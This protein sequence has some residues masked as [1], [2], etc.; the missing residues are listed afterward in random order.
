[1]IRLAVEFA[2]HQRSVGDVEMQNF[3]RGRVLVDADDP[4]RCN[5]I[6]GILWVGG[7]Y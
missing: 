1:M 6:Y 4:P 3:K 7:C 5:C 2:L